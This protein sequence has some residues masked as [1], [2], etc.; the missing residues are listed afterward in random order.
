MTNNL[1]DRSLMSLQTS[2]KKKEINLTD[3]IIASQARIKAVNPKINALITEVEPTSPGLP[4]VLKDSYITKGIRTTCASKVLADYIPDYNATIVEKLTTFGGALVGKGNQDAWGHGG[5]SENTD[6][7]PVKNPWDVTRVAGGSSGGPAA[8]VATRMSLFA[9]GE[10]T[11]GSIRS[12]AGWCNVTGLKVTYGRVSRYGCIAYASSFDTVGPLAKTAEDC[13]VVLQAIA[14]QDPYDAICSPTPV[15]NYTENLKKPITGLKIGLPKEFMSTITDKEVKKLIEDAAKQ[16]ETLG[17]EIVEVSLPM[18]EYA[19]PIY[20]LLAPAETSSNL[21][22]FDG[23]RYGD[24]RDKFS[25]E[26]KRRIML[27]T[28]ILSA[29]YHDKYYLKAQQ[30]RTLII[31]DYENIFKQCDVVLAPIAPTPPTKIG[32]LINDPINNWLAD[33]YTT[34]ASL[35]GIPSLAL[36]CGFTSGQ[37]PSGMQLQGPM[38]S[39][40]LLLRLGFNYQQATTW[41]DQTPNL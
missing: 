16:F 38:F 5:S 23:I 19:I 4:Y 36:P 39:E 11:G 9:I 30:A 22:R 24:S 29:G 20:Y 2:L 3:L 6:F 40:E 35:A 8:A 26:T 33:I 34:T 18:L 21:A 1:L 10:D 14:G 31:K 17:A 41:H 28:F 27:G 12:P 7:G 25:A 13:A 15:P 32:E 37:L